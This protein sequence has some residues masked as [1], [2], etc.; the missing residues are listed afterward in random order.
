MYLLYFTTFFLEISTGIFWWVT[1]KSITILINGVKY[2][3]SK[4]EILDDNLNIDKNY[5]SLTKDELEKLRNEIKE[6]KEL[7]VQKK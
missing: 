4:E 1:T 6:I 3:F 5:D 2:I 7:L